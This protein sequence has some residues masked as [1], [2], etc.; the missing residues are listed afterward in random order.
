MAA[1]S[2]SLGAVPAGTDTAS[3]IDRASAVWL[4]AG[5]AV[6]YAPT[7][8][9]LTAG[10]WAASAQ[11]HEAF[12]AA[13]AGWLIYRKRDAL[14]ALHSP[15]ALRSATLLLVAGLLM[16]VLGRSHQ[17]P[18]MELGSQLFVIA[19]AVVGWRGWRALRVIAF[20]LLFLAFVIPLP[21]TLTMTLTGPLKSGVSAVSTQLLFWAGSPVG[22][23]GVVITIGQYELLVATACAGLQTMFTLEALGLLYLHLRN[24]RSALRNALLALLV[25]PV[26]FGANVVRV[27]VLALVTYHFGDAA[28]RGF[29][30]GFAGMVLFLTALALIIAVDKLVAA[31]LPAPHRA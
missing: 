5:L 29:F 31:L 17:L 21:Y 28:G 4:L 18:R 3:R 12:V 24:Y 30:H 1:V 10:R 8:W 2:A 25:I 20:P 19:A 26:S 16:Y 7:Y 22:R 15:P 23:S 14:A 11:G 6:A 9:D 13:V 27:V